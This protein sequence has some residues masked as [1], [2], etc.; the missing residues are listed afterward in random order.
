MAISSK[1]VFAALTSVTIGPVVVDYAGTTILAFVVIAKID[2][3]V[4]ELS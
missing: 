2:W 3:V 1:E 4:A